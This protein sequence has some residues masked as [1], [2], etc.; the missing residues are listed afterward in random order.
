M[1]VEIPNALALPAQNDTNT[2]DLAMSKDQTLSAADSLKTGSNDA[3]VS[4]IN[5]TESRNADVVVISETVITHVDLESNGPISIQSLSNTPVKTV[6]KIDI[7]IDDKENHQPQN[8]TPTTTARPKLK[9]FKRNKIT[10]PPKA[11][12]SFDNHPSFITLLAEFFK[13]ST[14]GNEFLALLVQDQWADKPALIKSISK[15]LSSATKLSNEQTIEIETFLD[16]N[17][18]RNNYGLATVANPSWHT[19]RWDVKPELI[20]A[21]FRD[22][23]LLKQAERAKIKQEILEYYNS[24]S[25]QEK[26]EMG[27][28]KPMESLGE[29]TL[30]NVV[31]P[32]QSAVVDLEPEVQLETP[33]KVLKERKR[34]S[35]DNTPKTPKAQAAAPKSAKKAKVDKSQPT[36]SSFFK[37]VA[38]KTVQPVEA[39]QVS[40]LMFQPFNVKAGVHLAD[41]NSFYRIVSNS[42]DWLSTVNSS[43][44]KLGIID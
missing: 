14:L 1:D 40:N 20:P 5:E 26:I 36:L 24:L 39:L 44:T 15:K 8:S 30:V 12:M 28:D 17:C 37:P 22:G 18:V 16:C 27:L 29:A 42:R 34:K 7:N 21:E 38:K 41:H 19:Y 9:Y 10:L 13:S 35:Q 23:I 11:T 6:G 33:V 4:M 43:D 3:D 2:I 25:S 31:L 32:I